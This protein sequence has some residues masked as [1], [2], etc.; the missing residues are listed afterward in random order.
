MTRRLSGALA[1]V[2]L[3]AA[4]AALPAV[5]GRAA[6]EPGRVPGPKK[7]HH[8]VYFHRDRERISDPAFLRTEALEG[9]QLAYTWSELEPRKDAYDFSDIRKD[10]AFLQAQRKKLFI[11]LQDVSFD[12][13]IIN[14]PRYLRE[15]PRYHGGVAR[16]Y[17][18]E[19]EDEEHARPEGW[20]ARRWDPAVRE[21]FHRLLKALGAAFDGRIEGINLAE[22]SV[23]FGERGGLF[24]A[25]FT[26]ERYRDAVLETTAAL[27]S[28]FP[29]SVTLRY[30][31]FMPGE[32][33]P[34]NDRG[35]LRAVY[36][37]ARELKVG[38]G[39]PD[40]LPFK[41]GQM[42]HSY[43]LIRECDGSVPIGIAVQWGNY[44]HRNPKTG[45]RVTTAEL[46]GFAGDYLRADYLFWCT[47]EPYYS[48]EVLPFLRRAK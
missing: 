13:A 6:G 8:Y 40:L 36:R 30:A 9:A 5:A 43:P 22:T 33:L 18:I 21:R 29:R 16:Q 31:N 3:I 20:V 4:A 17:T 41:P 45:R 27:K 12:G 28:A 25:D 42:N 14:V 1:W 19:G 39:G 26:F 44:E 46:V 7:I 2:L 34:D 47:Q 32:W 48:E 37:R 10:L 11:Q 38:I 24:P 23:N 35:Y 15:D